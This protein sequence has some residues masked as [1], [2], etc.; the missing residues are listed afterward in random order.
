MKKK[1]HKKEHHGHH[2]KE[3]EK[4]AHKKHHSAHHGKKQHASHSEHQEAGHDG[5]KKSHS[6][7]WIAGA[8]KHPGA[9]RKELHAKKG[10]K[11]PAEKLKKAAHHGGVEGRRAR[12]A[13]TLKRLGH[14]KHKKGE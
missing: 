12:L 10:H 14:R 4:K 13:M 5:H 9:L 7:M 3:H 6:K 11:I 8:I 1:H 2:K